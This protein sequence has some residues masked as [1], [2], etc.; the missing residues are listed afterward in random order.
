M[1]RA[2]VL[3]LQLFS[4]IDRKGNAEERG[5]QQ[6]LIENLRK[7][8]KSQGKGLPWSLRVKNLPCNAGDIGSIPDWGTKIQHAME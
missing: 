3:E 7:K 8:K 6:E 4:V 1:P 2:E 5:K